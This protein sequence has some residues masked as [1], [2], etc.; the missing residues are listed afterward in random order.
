MTEHDEHDRE[1]EQII[2]QRKARARTLA[3]RALS[4][5]IE[6]LERDY[7]YGG[8]HCTDGHDVMA[9]TDIIDA[10][11]N[12][13][14]ELCAREP[15]LTGDLYW[16][17]VRLAGAAVGFCFEIDR[18]ILEAASKWAEAKS[19]AEQIRQ[20]IAMTKEH[21]Q[22]QI[23]AGTP[24]AERIE[25]YLGFLERDAVRREKGGNS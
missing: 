25:K 18:A 20:R 13:L 5:A 12:Q 22:S 19:A 9:W 8:W 4:Q 2:K 1:S 15:M 11:T 7:D 21:I 10:M 14:A 24:A 3:K 23:P 6:A 16:G 17:S